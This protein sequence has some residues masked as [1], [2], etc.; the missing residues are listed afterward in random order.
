[1]IVLQS[2]ISSTNASRATGVTADLNIST[3]VRE[4]EQFS[5]DLFTFSDQFV[6]L[7]K[8]T[9]LSQT[10]L[11]TARASG[12]GL[13]QRINAAQQHFRSIIAKLKAANRWDKL[14]A[15]ANAI[16]TSGQSRVILQRAGG[17]KKL[18]E[19]L[20]NNLGGLAQEIEGQVQKLSS[21]I[22]SQSSFSESELRNR[23]LR[24]AYQP[25]PV[26][27]DS[28]RCNFAVGSYNL[29][30]ILLGAPFPP[31]DRIQHRIDRLCGS[32]A[33]GDVVQ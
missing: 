14:D 11:A 26:V 12:N 4:L 19:D 21:R 33:S 22:Q 25:A 28:R 7:S 5:D 30:I 15:E 27:A 2:L 18:Y 20:A 24:V 32:E 17:A 31:P 29:R 6:T 9:R 13:K 8:K 1:V 3:E 16:I 10:E 23:A